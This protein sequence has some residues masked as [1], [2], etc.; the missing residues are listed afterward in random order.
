MQTWQKIVAIAGG[1]IVG[2]LGVAAIVYPSMSQIFG[3][4]S[5]AL[6]LLIATMTGISIVKGE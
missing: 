1:A 3:G 2:G 5:G 4:V 6:G